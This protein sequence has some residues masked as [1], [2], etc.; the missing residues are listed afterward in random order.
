[1]STITSPS[2]SPAAVAGAT[3][4]EQLRHWLPLAVV[5]TG[6]FMSVLDFFIVNV[7]LPNM[8]H[9]LHASASDLEWTSAGYA[10]ATAVLLVASGRLGDRFGRRATFTAGL[11]VFTVGSAACGVAPTATTLVIGRVVQGI[12]AAL[13]AT[14]V[15]SLIGVLYV[16]SERTVAL[17]AYAAV[18]GVAAIFGQLIGGALLALDPAGLDWRSVFLINLPIGAAGVLAAIRLVPESRGEARSL[19]PLGIA[20]VSTGLVALV[21]P[22]VEGRQL[23]WPLWGWLCLGAAPLILGAFVVQQR[24]LD[25][26]G[27]AP[28]LEL[29]LFRQR[30]FAAGMLTQTVFWS[31][32]ASF[33]LIL[34]LYLQGG[35]GLSPIASGCVFAI[36]AVSYVFVSMRAPGLAVRHGRSVIT[37]AGL[38]LL[39]AHLLLIGA[40]AL[41]GTGGSVFVL[42]PGLI[43]AGIGMGLGIGPLSANLL[44]TLRP[45]QAGS[46]A[47]ALATAQ[48]VGNALGVAIVGVAFFGALHGG[49]APALEAGL[50]VLAGA[51]ALVAV[52]SRALPAS[53]AGR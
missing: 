11:A 47:G 33:F 7:A 4:S 20:L 41:F 32:Q 38:T 46:A 10:L 48:F 50:A 9:S 28:L 17:S 12:G 14:N 26:Q 16:G 27:G 36:L 49:Y 51:V 5:L 18:M 43:A 52:L 23:G 40:V 22:L 44:A 53:E 29:G 6:T 13:L 21:L 3:R 15:M 35:R 37:A 31:G 19:D 8:Q 39:G 24:R 25:R 2:P 45:E 30:A 34:A 1:M 42:A